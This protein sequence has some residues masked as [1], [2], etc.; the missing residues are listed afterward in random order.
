MVKVGVGV[1][2]LE[3]I[4]GWARE[5]AP[6]RQDFTGLQA[7][8]KRSLVSLQPEQRA[9]RLSEVVTPNR[10]HHAT[11]SYF[12]IVYNQTH[13]DDTKG[14]ASWWMAE[15]PER[16]HFRVA[17]LAGPAPSDQ[18]LWRFSKGTHMC[19]GKELGLDAS[20]IEESRRCARKDAGLILS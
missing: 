4:G 3:G 15:R 14:G 8:V 13:Y 12:L 6:V 20:S 7:G 10:V 19:H 16:P 1:K 18:L 17:E 5:G 11:P 9:C 2:A